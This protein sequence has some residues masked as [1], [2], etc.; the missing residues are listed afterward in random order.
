MFSV[1]TNCDQIR[2]EKF[3]HATEEKLRGVRCPEHHQAPR[4]RF[5]GDSLRN[6]NISLTGCCQKLMDI[7]NQRIAT[8]HQ[9]DEN[10]SA[11]AS[12]LRKPA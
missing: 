11:R 5:Q 3:K 1:H 12:S 4:L 6:I 8:T 2:V 10:Q 9:A 7:A